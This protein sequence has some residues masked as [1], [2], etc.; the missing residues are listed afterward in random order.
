MSLT[1]K[2]H[3]PKPLSG[4]SMFD[5]IGQFSRMS[6]LQGSNKLGII[7]SPWPDTCG[8]KVGTCKPLA[9]VAGAKKCSLHPQKLFAQMDLG[10]SSTKYH[11]PNIFQFSLVRI[12]DPAPILNSTCPWRCPKAKHMA[13][14]R[15]ACSG[16]PSTSTAEQQPA[17]NRC[18]FLPRILI[19]QGFNNPRLLLRQHD[20]LAPKSRTISRLKPFP[21]FMG[22]LR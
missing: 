8:M 22:I 12:E 6:S 17:K 21:S 15:C 11:G 3:I 18:H 4:V 7:P 13:C 2:C 14:S 10:N 20:Y 5:A 9:H 1:R 16:S 19:I